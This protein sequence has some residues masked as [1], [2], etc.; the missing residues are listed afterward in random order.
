MTGEN[1]RQ[2]RK[3]RYY[4]FVPNLRISPNTL[5]P[6]VSNLSLARS[7]A[8]DDCTGVLRIARLA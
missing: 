8:P 2:I 6:F 5:S 7:A 3:S 4:F 1:G